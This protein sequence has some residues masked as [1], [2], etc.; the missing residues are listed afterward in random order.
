MLSKQY[1]LKLLMYSTKKCYM[2]DYAYLYILFYSLGIVCAANIQLLCQYVDKQQQN[3]DS[4]TSSY[5]QKPKVSLTTLQAV[6]VQEEPRWS[7]GFPV[8]LPPPPPPNHHESPPTQHDLTTNLPRTRQER[9]KNAT[10][11]FESC[12]SVPNERRLDNNVPRLRPDV[13]DGTTN[14][15]IHPHNTQYTTLKYSTPAIT[16]STPP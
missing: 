4:T 16:H 14:S 12:L 15:T 13:A 2:W 10:V 5:D 3:G 8:V 7:Y 1:R 11:E 6:T 9:A